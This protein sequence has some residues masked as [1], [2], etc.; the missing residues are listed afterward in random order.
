MSQEQITASAVISFSQ[1][2][3]DQSADFYDELSELFDDYED[4]FEDMAKDCKRQRTF[5]VRTYQETISDALEACFAFEGLDFGR[6]AADVELPE[7]IGYAEALTKAIALEDLAAA[8][9]LD[10]AERSQSFLATIP[11]A[12]RRVGQKHAARKVELQEMLAEA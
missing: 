11:Q 12:F 1:K 5:V 9:Y 10:I 7:G 8:F 3:E 4:E 2:L 6:Y